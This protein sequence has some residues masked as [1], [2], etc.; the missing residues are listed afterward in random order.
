MGNGG[1]AML[2]L[3]KADITV[4]ESVVPMIALF[5]AATRETHGGKFWNYDGT[6]KAW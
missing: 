2:G 5:D 1:A 4:E 6:Q 3:E